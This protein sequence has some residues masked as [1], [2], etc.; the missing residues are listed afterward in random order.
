MAISNQTGCGIDKEVD[1]TAMASILDLRDF[2]SWLI[3]FSTIAH[4]LQKNS[5]IVIE[6]GMMAHSVR[7]Q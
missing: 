2:L 6:N 4:L 7:I 1:L 5:E 3:I